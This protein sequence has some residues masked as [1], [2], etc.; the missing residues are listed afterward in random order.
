MRIA[1]KE[2]LGRDKQ[3]SCF[4]GFVDMWRH[5]LVAACEFGN[6]RYLSVEFL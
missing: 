6:E 3:C 2:V 4:I 5:P 1:A